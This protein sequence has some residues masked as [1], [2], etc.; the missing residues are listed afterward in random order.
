MKLLARSF[1]M[2]WAVA[3]IMLTW[4]SSVTTEQ[5]QLGEFSHSAAPAP[6]GGQLFSGFPLGLS[7]SRA[8]LT[9]RLRIG[10]SWDQSWDQSSHII[11]TINTITPTAGHSSTHMLSSDRFLEKPDC[12]QVQQVTGVGLHPPLQPSVSYIYI[13]LITSPGMRHHVVTRPGHAKLCVASLPPLPDSTDS[14]C[15][16]RHCKN[17]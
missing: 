6:A 3:E 11:N 9:D 1:L 17:L 2:T 12:L 4:L 14:P 5:Q 10:S 16:G 13:L 7:Q 15:T 8:G